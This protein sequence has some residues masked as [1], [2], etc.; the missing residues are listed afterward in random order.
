MDGT[1][2]Y[3]NWDGGISLQFGYVGISGKC[4]DVSRSSN[5]EALF[6]DVI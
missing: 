1:A 4:H 6:S 5:E 2:Y 3:V